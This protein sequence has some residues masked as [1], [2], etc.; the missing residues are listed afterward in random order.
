MTY[1]GVGAVPC[2]DSDALH[3]WNPYPGRRLHTPA[4][5]PV[6]STRHV[7]FCSTVTPDPWLPKDSGTN[8]PFVPPRRRPMASAFGLPA[9]MEDLYR[10]VYPGSGTPLTDVARSLLVQPDE[11]LADLRPLLASDIVRVEN[12]ILH[13]ASP[14]EAVSRYVASQ[15]RQVADAAHELTRLSRAIPA[16]A[17]L[18][19]DTGAVEGAEPIDGEVSEGANVPQMLSQWIRES[20]GDLSFMRPDQ[21]RLPSESEMAAV[22]ND[23]IR[24]GRVV[25][26]LYPIGA[27]K[28]APAVLLGRAAIGE[29]IRV[30]P[31][32]PTRMAIIGPSRALLPD[33]LGVGTERRIALRQPAL[34]DVLQRWF[35]LL[36]EQATAV[37]ALDRGDPRPDLRRLLLAQLAE[38]AKDEQIARTLGLSLRTV[39][40]R[41]AGLMV[42]LGAD[43]R[44]Q[45]GVEA[46]RRGWI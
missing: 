33:P 23:A 22:V 3:A 37:P 34:V 7:T 24:E 26:A 32:L 8:M 10:R 40:R 11:L 43:T 31:S 45:A 1:E 36:W 29:Q 5:P 15:A 44:F 38:G 12:G 42:E 18:G 41:V 2:G 6:Y 46:A 13:V 39:R 27:F 17:E 16:L 14:V 9:A 28:E 21:W 20:V 35:D 4:A 30:L 19:D 25:R